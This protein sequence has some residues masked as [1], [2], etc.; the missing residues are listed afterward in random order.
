MRRNLKDTFSLKALRFLLYIP[1]IIIKIK[2][3]PLFILSYLGLKNEATIFYFR[4]GIKIKTESWIDAITIFVIF[5][6]KDYGNIKDDSIVIDIGANIGI[7]CIYA[8]LTSRNSVVYAYEPVAQSYNLLVENIKLNNIEN[9]VF[10]FQKGVGSTEEERKIFLSNSSQFHSLYSENESNKKFIEISLISLA[11]VFVLNKLE[12][13]DVL[14]LDCKGAEFEI[15]Y[16]TSN[17]NFKNIKEIRLEYHN[18]KIKDYNIDSLIKFIES[19]GFRLTYFK[20]NEEVGGNA[21][22]IN[23]N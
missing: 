3:Y 12:K 22:F 4:N 10:S 1:I 5:I 9:K 14:K 23:L 2:N 17:E 18:Q 7:F 21:W 16:N 19:K 20:K 13:C 11:D 8:A 15:L 6:R